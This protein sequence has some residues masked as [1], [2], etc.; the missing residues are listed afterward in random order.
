MEKLAFPLPH[1]LTATVWDRHRRMLNRTQQQTRSLDPRGAFS[2]LQSFHS[3]SV[4]SK[5]TETLNQTLMCETEEI[6]VGW[7]VWSE[8]RNV[9]DALCGVLQESICHLVLFR[10]ILYI[11]LLF[12]WLTR[13]IY[14]TCHTSKIYVSWGLAIVFNGPLFPR[15][16]SLKNVF[17][18][19]CK[20]KRPCSMPLCLL[21]LQSL[22]KVRGRWMD[23]W[24]QFGERNQGLSQS[25]AK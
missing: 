5:N 19:K 10:C 24:R 2:L 6:S 11:L 21:S 8:R 14:W 4:K 25:A 15:P 23:T 22:C 13:W 16:H 12:H 9:T 18:C 17:T 3:H 20:Q 1:A 7:V